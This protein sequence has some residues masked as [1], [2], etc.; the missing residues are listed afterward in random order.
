MHFY[1]NSGSI[2]FATG[3]VLHRNMSRLDILNMATQWEDWIV[4]HGVPSAYR[5]IMK[6]P[7]RGSSSKTILI[8]YFGILD[9]P[10]AF[11]MLAP[12]DLSDGAQKQPEGKYNKRMRKW[13]FENFHA[14]LPCGDDWGQVDATYDP[15]NQSTSIACNYRE[16]FSTE[17]EWRKYRNENKF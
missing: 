13:F 15:W 2:E 11:W 16:R 8:V 17:D 12:W 5:T 14:V 9:G 6:L 3:L 7:N 4:V 1:K 10:L